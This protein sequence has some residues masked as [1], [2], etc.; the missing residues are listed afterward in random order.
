MNMHLQNVKALAGTLLLSVGLVAC[1]P[2]PQVI[3]RISLG[4]I[5]SADP[6]PRNLIDTP[7]TAIRT[8]TTLVTIQ[9]Q[10]LIPLHGEA[11]CL[12]WSD[13]RQTLQWAGGIAYVDAVKQ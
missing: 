12:T 3:D 7:K 6:L 11:W 2:Q 8:T 5:L 10:P 4:E 9:S 13:G 1:R